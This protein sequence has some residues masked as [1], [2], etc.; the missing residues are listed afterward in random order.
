MAKIRDLK[1][2]INYLTFEVLSD[3][4]VYRIVN[5]ESTEKVDEIM[6]DS[7]KMRNELLHRI[8][9]VKILK[10]TKEI[11]K[12][13]KSIEEDLINHADNSFKKLSELAK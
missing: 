3:C 11:K 1:K 12:E 6:S 8:G 9:E 7:V 2:D 13:F 5:T 10:N 4:M